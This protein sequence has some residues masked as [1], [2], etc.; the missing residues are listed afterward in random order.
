MKIIQSMNVIFLINFQE[1]SSQAALGARRINRIAKL[2][3]MPVVFLKNPLSNANICRESSLGLLLFLYRPPW[4]EPWAE[5]FCWLLLCSKGAPPYFWEAL[6]W[7]S[8]PD[9][10]S[11]GG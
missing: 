5:G 7:S 2:N 11:G 4:F 8:P 10:S 6:R 9:F 3:S 1:L